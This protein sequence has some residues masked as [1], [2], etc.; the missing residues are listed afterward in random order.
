M[1][2]SDRPGRLGVQVYGET[3]LIAEIFEEFVGDYC[4]FVA[5]EWEEWQEAGDAARDSRLEMISN[6]HKGIEI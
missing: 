4:G 3:G 2:V 1:N 6:A 5:A